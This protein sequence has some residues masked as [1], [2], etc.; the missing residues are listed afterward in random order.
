MSGWLELPTPDNGTALVQVS[1]I[2]CVV[3]YNERSAIWFGAD[4]CIQVTVS[5]EDLRA[6][7]EPKQ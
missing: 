6:M 3:R 1:R 2:N 4:D 7:L 5:I